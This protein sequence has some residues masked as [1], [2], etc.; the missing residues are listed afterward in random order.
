MKVVICI[1]CEKNTRTWFAPKKGSSA[2][3]RY[4]KFLHIKCFNAWWHNEYGDG[5]GPYYWYLRSGMCVR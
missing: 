1:R 5:K 3:G 2:W 4:G